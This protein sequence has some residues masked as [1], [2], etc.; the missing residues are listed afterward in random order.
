MAGAQAFSV[1]R[2]NPA[3]KTYISVLDMDA[4]FN[5]DTKVKDG[6]VEVKFQDGTARNWKACVVPDSITANN[7]LLLIIA[8]AS[9][10]DTSLTGTP[11]LSVSTAN[12]W[13]TFENG[14]GNPASTTVLENVVVILD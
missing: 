8:F 9:C 3:A 10:S 12:F 6:I 4:N 14:N 13:I 5:A 2:I 1:V 7:L 11:Q